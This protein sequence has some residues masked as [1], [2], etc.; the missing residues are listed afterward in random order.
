M[1][2]KLVILL[3][4][5][6]SL[7]TG[8]SQPVIPYS[9]SEIY[10]SLRKLNILGSVLYIAAHPDDE[11]T[12]LLAYLSKEKLY[13]TG[14]LSLT[15]GD[16][17]QNLVGDEQ[18]IELGLIRT[19]ELLAARRIDGAEQFF[20]RAFDFGYSKNPE[21]TLEKWDRE[22]ILSDMVWVIRTFKPDVIITRFPETGEGGHGHHTS[23]AILAKEAFTAAA[24]PKKFPA[25]LKWVS[26]W[27]PTRLLWNTFRF[28]NT[29]TINEN[30]F[31]IDVGDYNALL[32]KSY[33]EISAESR[34]QHKSQGFGVPA[35]RGEAFEY[36]SATLGS[37]PKKELFDDVNTNWSKI[38]GGDEISKQ[39]ES[40]I[41]S[42]DLFHPEKSVNGLTQLYR[43]INNLQGNYW[44]EQKL[45]E[46]KE[47]IVACSGLWIDAYTDRPTAVQTDSLKF[48][49][50]LNDRA[51]VGTVFQKFSI[52]DFD[53]V[54]NYSLQKNRNLVISKQIYVP[55]EKEITQ[56]FWLQSDKAEGYYNITNQE[57]IGKP[58]AIPAY[59]VH[60]QVKINDVS[61]NWQL[62]VRY[63]YTDPVKGEIYEP[64]VV[65]PPVTVQT[66]EDIKIS[67]N[68]NQFDGILQINAHA[69]NARVSKIDVKVDQP[70]QV[71]QEYNPAELIFQER[72]KSREIQ[73]HIEANRDNQY[74]FMMESAPSNNKI[75]LKEWKKIRY[76]H[77]PPIYYFSDAKVINRNLDLKIV[78]KEIGYIP[79]AGDKIPEA[80]T[81]MGYQVT[82]LNE[83]V[84]AQNDLQKFDAIITGVRAYNTNEWLNKYYSRLMKYIE[85]GGNLVVQYNTSNNIGPVKAHIG[86]YP[87][88]ISRTRITNETSPVKFLKPSHSILNF[89]NKINQKDF[90]GW[91]QERSIYHASELDERF[92]T[93]LAMN[94]PGEESQDGSLIVAKYGKGSFVYT[95]L[96]FFRQLPAGIPG[97]YR[98]LANIIAL[99]KYKGF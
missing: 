30:Q 59:T 37:E 63:R 78:G 25:Q 51:G 28:G 86:P 44:K 83:K 7:I 88:N 3:F 19:Q 40:L 61:F 89:P 72:N 6:F 93:V 47:L 74:S 52:E 73:Y 53:S 22:K 60:A 8:F 29:N 41:K 96:V 36:F 45:K 98:L 79:G 34:S 95:G 26:V 55:F 20:T 49:L 70:G 76:D 64:L 58:D 68:N 99:N 80:L 1:Q 12:R 11:N 42:F 17:G 50:V 57:L 24:D 14:Y 18:G 2:R 13:R 43:S 94:D 48:N 33:G 46:V 10:S 81:Q 23:S 65:V 39:V 21:E 4:F 62:P 54:L 35:G 77:I 16:G 66:D 38:K 90:E 5:I 75:G 15:R 92:E 85:D 27:K 87:F 32:G 31:K 56:P 84:L 82:I 71:K 67:M 69:D 97:A 9:S 91:I